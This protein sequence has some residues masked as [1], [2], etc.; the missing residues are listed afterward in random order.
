MWESLKTW[1]RRFFNGWSIADVVKEAETGAHAAALL[2]EKAW[3]VWS[4]QGRTA[5]RCWAYRDA[6]CEVF[7]R[8]GI[9]A[10]VVHVVPLEPTVVVETSQG[11]VKTYTG[12]TGVMWEEDGWWW[13]DQF[14]QQR[15]AIQSEAERTFLLEC[16][17]DG[18]IDEVYDA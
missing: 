13:A 14:G 8:L 9:P 18:R 7:G 1:F 17:F 16:K 12:H 11:V 4:S 10:K 15:H 3:P 5:D 6:L 2:R